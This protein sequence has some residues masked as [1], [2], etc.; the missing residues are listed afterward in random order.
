MVGMQEKVI[1]KREN[2]FF[3]INATIDSP[4]F[5]YCLFDVRTFV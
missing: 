2:S 5:V 4:H 3:Q 1:W